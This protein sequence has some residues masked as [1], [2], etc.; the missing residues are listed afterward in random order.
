MARRRKPEPRKRGRPKAELR[1]NSVEELAARGC[2]IEE[3]AGILGVNR[4]TVSDNFSAEVARGRNRLAEQLRGRQVDLAM[5]G[6]VPLLIWL[7]KQYL[8][9]REKTDAVV[10]EEVITIEEL[11][12]KVQHDA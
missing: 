6:S 11:P 3:I 2:T 9:Q 7:G 10:R 5:N 4:D 12:P 8:G 1:K